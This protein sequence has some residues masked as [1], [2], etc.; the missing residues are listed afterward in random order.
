MV[1]EERMHSMTDIKP[2]YPPLM[3]AVDVTVGQ[4]SYRSLARFNGS[5]PSLITCV[6][7]SLVDCRWP[8]M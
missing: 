1:D 7:P 4:K 3:K 6:Y 8:Q 2:D 5:H